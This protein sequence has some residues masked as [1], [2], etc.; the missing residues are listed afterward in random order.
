MA[1]VVT[2]IVVTCPDC[3]VQASVGIWSCGCQVVLAP[4]HRPACAIRERYFEAFQ[5]SC[6]IGKGVPGRPEVH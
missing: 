5:R 4:P 6:E 2:A 3:G 1:S